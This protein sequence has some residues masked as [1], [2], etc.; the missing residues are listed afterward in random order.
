MDTVIA[1]AP[2]LRGVQGQVKGHKG[3]CCSC[4]TMT[5]GQGAG[6]G[7]LSKPMEVSEDTT[8]ELMKGGG[9]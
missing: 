6:V 4:C 1:T 2:S 5:G 8:D 9:E 3:A 7:R